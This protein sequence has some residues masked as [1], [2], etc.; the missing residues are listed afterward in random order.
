MQKKAKCTIGLSGGVDSSI[1]AHLIKDD[2]QLTALFM[3]NWDGNE[4]P[5]QDEYQRATLIA[6]QLDIPIQHINGSELY[7]EKV[8]K[9]FIHDLH[10][11]FTPNPDIWCNEFVKFDLLTQL[12]D[13]DALISTGHYAQVIKN[14]NEYTLHRAKDLNKDQSYFLSR[15]QP[16]H[17]KRLLLPLG[18]YQKNQIKQMAIELKLASAYQKESMG[19]CFI[20]PSNYREFIKNY[21]IAKPGEIFSD[22]DIKL[23]EHQGLLYY[24]IGQ[25]TGH[26]VGGVKNHPEGPWYVIEKDL[27]S[28]RLI[29]SQNSNHPK[30][31]RDTCIISDIHYFT[32]TFPKE[33]LAQ[34]RHRMI[35][36]KCT[37]LKDGNNLKIQFNQKQWALTAGQHIAL[38]EYD[39]LIMSGVIQTFSDIS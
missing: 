26:G 7:Y 8:F 38:Y 1:A 6:K 20:G 4:C 32:K 27:R 14:N 17:L 39:K 24:T 31:M 19:I 23:G 12:A 3:Q 30:L 34:F 9:R 10:L 22:R 15:L 2:Y 28:N 21:V 18:S 5:W 13:E 16:E 25:R 36:Q 29:L 11:G 35:P 37:I 33:L